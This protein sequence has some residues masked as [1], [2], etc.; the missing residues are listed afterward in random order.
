M[1]LSGLTTAVKSQPEINPAHGIVYSDQPVRGHVEFEVQITSYLVGMRRHG[2]I[3][4][5]IMLCKSGEPLQSSMIPPDSLKAPNYCLW[6]G[7]TLYDNIRTNARVE[8]GKKS[9]NDLRERDRVGILITSN[10][11]LHFLIN[12]DPQGE[13][14]HNIYIP[15]YDV[16][17]IVDHW[18][19][20]GATQITR[21]SKQFS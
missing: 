21:A 17:I 8:Y 1:I 14:V 11:E 19:K 20:C 2:S 4:I 12:G 9:L 7:S 10:E 5:G 18:S 6:A 16:Y 13:A 3:S 15:G